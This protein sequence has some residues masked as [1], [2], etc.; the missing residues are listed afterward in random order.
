[1]T[2]VEKGGAAA[3]LLLALMSYPVQLLAAQPS[4]DI[5][6][7]ELDQGSR[8]APKATKAP[9]KHKKPASAHRSEPATQGKGKEVADSGA[10]YLRY[11]VKPGDHLFKILVG[12]LGMSNEKAERLIPEIIRL[13]DIGNH[14]NLKVGRTLLIPRGHQSQPARSARKEPAPVMAAAEP[15][16]SVV[17]PPPAVHPAAAAAAPAPHAAKPA[18]LEAKLVSEHTSPAQPKSAPVPSAAAAQPEPAPTLPAAAQQA[19]AG[20]HREPYPPQGTV[21]RHEPVQTLQETVAALPA[22]PALPD[23]PPVASVPARHA[24]VCSVSDKEPGQ[25]IDALL[26]V[27]SVNWSK[28][29]ILESQKDSPMA[30]SIMVDRYFEHGGTRYIIT[31]GDNDPYNYTLLRLLEAEGYKVLRLSGKEQFQDLG[32]KVLKLVGVSPAF[33]SYP[34]GSGEQHNRGFLLQGEDAG[35]RTV[36]VTSERVDA[37]Q[38]AALASGCNNLALR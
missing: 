38:K 20:R 30:Y 9:A 27:M 5:D 12:N 25:V 16:L 26:N 6:L 14:K 17:A 23:P 10:G 29:R 3:L 33:G 21:L 2:T 8:T 37:K 24:L 28:N 7:K 15:P 34:V 22:R 19:G 35:G 31:V 36:V 4:F 1:M 11:T 32:Q 13:N 18:E